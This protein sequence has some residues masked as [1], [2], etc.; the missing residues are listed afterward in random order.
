MEHELDHERLDVYR[1]ARDLARWVRQTRFPA[2]ESALRDQVRRAA[3][4]VPLNIAEGCHRSG[5]DRFQHFRIAKGS[6]AECCAILDLV[7]LP[8]GPAHQQ[9]FRRVVAMLCHLR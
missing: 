2:G 8:D 5:G 6:A 4:S 7:D 3:D 1:L 9:E